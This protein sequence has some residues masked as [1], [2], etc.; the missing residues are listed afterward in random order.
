MSRRK[1]LNR[2]NKYLEIKHSSVLLSKFINMIM[3]NG[4]KNIAEKIIYKTLSYV[5][6]KIKKD[7]ILILESVLDKVRPIVEVKSRR[8]GGSTYQVPIEIRPERRDSLAIRWIIESARNK[9]GKSM[10]EGLISEFLDIIENKGMAI[11]KRDELHKI[12]EANKAF[13]HYRW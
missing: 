1:L 2:P 5:S 12:A 3:L 4:K 11:K 10:I 6:K 8:V 7:E 13:A 9:K